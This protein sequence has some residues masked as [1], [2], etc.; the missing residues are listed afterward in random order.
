LKHYAEGAVSDDAVR[1]VAERLT[2]GPCAARGLQDVAPALEVA[3][4]EMP[5]EKLRGLRKRCDG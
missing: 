3:V 2:V 1:G 5:L 4:Y